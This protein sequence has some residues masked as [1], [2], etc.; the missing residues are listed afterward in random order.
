MDASQL[1]QT[2][3]V[4]SGQVVKAAGGSEIVVHAH[5]LP[6]EAIAPTDHRAGLAEPYR[7]RLLTATTHGTRR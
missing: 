3:L 2:A 1:S 4:V 6:D 7:A 5:A